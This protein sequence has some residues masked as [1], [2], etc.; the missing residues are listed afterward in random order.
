M[1]VN[2]RPRIFFNHYSFI[3]HLRCSNWRWWIYSANYCN[4]ITPTLWEPRRGSI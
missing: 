1:P 2:H 3:E 4:K